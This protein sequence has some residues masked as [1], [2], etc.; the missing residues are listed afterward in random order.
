[1]FVPPTFVLYDKKLTNAEKQAIYNSAQLVIKYWQAD[2]PKT[3]QPV[4]RKDWKNSR[5]SSPPVRWG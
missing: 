1:M 2:L 4:V 5:L 3:I